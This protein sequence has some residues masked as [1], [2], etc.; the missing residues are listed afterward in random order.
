MKRSK[1]R[2]TREHMEYA[3][4]LEGL[5]AQARSEET[6]IGGFLFQGA[7]FSGVDFSKCSFQNCVFEGCR[8]TDGTLAK[9]AFS[10]CLFRGCDFSGCSLENGY[11]SRCELHAC[12]GV[13]CRLCGCLLRDVLFWWVWLGWWLWGWGA[14]SVIAVGWCCAEGCSGGG[15][16][17]CW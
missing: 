12:K 10:D 16:S 11:F 3:G 5:A 9:A 6:D 7:D 15:W 13:G 14:C 8:F 1:P 4:E 2:L 17:W